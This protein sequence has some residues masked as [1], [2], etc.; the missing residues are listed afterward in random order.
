MEI[1]DSK[2][3][4]LIS[5]LKAYWLHNPGKKIILFSYFK[6][7]LRYLKARL[8]KDGVLSQLLYGG[9]DKDI[10]LSNFQN[11]SSINV[12]LA[13]EVASEG[14]DLQFSSLVIN[15]DLPW[16]PM[17]VEQRIGRIDRIGQAEKKI[18]IWNF[19][20]QDSIDDRIYIRL[21][22]KLMIFEEALG[23]MG[24]IIGDRLE[25]MAKQY[26][27]HNLS[28]EQLKQLEK[29]EDQVIEHVKNLEKQLDEKSSQL[30][31]HGDFIQQSIQE[32]RAFGRYIKAEDLV[33]YFET[34]IKENY[35]PSKINLLDQSHN[36]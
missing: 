17:R 18:L 23:G 14:V 2:Y 20:Y 9:L 33:V 8:E 28:D 13:S 32:A 31:A 15:Y 29:Q 27:L 4:R 12:L 34:F 11:S 6:A 21:Y 16:N 1:N 24:E 10:A 7:T 22:N 3:N 36:K 19:F 26:L 30:V 5:Q 35:Q 25:S